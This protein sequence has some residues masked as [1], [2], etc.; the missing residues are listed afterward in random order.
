M[1]FNIFCQNFIKKYIFKVGGED[2]PAGAIPPPI[3]RCEAGLYAL[4]GLGE[5]LPQAHSYLILSPPHLWKLASH[6]VSAPSS[7]TP[8]I[9]PVT[10]RESLVLQQK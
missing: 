5:P 6:H 7:L 8:L 3:H 9:G 1:K 10:P 4:P 2:G